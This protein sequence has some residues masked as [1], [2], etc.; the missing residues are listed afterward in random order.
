MRPGRDVVML[1]W[2]AVTAWVTPHLAAA[3]LSRR[4]LPSR[5]YA[6][7]IDV[8]YLGVVT[9]FSVSEAS[10][11]RWCRP[12]RAGD[13]FLPFG[14]RR[15]RS[16]LREG[17]NGFL[18]RVENS[19][20]EVDM[21]PSPC[22]LPISCFGTIFGR[23]VAELPPAENAT[24]LEAAILSRWRSRPRQDRGAFGCRDLV[25]TARP[26]PSAVYA[27]L[28][29]GARYLRACPMTRVED[30]TSPCGGHDEQSYGVSDHVYFP[31][32]A[33]CSFASALLL[34][35]ETFQQRQ[36]THRAEETVRFVGGDRENQFLGV[37]R[38]SSSRVVRLLSSG[39]VHAGRRRRGGET[40]QQ[41]QGTHRAEETVRFVGG[42][43][44][45][46]FL[47][48]GRGLDP[49]PYE[50]L[51]NPA[52][53][54]AHRAT[55]SHAVSSP[56]FS[57]EAAELE[58]L[59]LEMGPDL[60][61]ELRGTRSHSPEVFPHPSPFTTLESLDPLLS[62][63]PEPPDHP[64][65][66][67]GIFSSPPPDPHNHLVGS[68][69]YPHLFPHLSPPII[70]WVLRIPLTYL[71]LLSHPITLCI[72]R[73]SFHI[74]LSH[75]TFFLVLR[76]PLFLLHPSLLTVGGVHLL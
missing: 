7:S 20:L 28:S 66:T 16:F 11:L 55:F 6:C 38:G 45:N 31:Y 3:F 33:S 36:G 44:E 5:P 72:L 39:R 34:V 49:L 61:R 50:F 15:R 41:R 43:R 19:M 17:P 68:K 1:E 76:N 9:T 37:G 21:L 42:D 18:L 4:G 75:L 47:G 51:S 30:K 71:F 57:D 64:L 70:F 35:G 40:F 54:K 23:R 46:R 56:S 8:A 59:L 63:P 12:A 13:V 22:G 69:D 65:G 73:V 53:P 29:P 32:R 2:S 24:P 25:A 14:V 62:P 60:G 48:V 52:K 67:Q 10:M 58:R 26:F 74:Y 27:S